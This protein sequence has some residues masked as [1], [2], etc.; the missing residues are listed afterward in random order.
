MQQTGEASRIDPKDTESMADVITSIALCPDANKVFVACGRKIFLFNSH[1]DAMG[2]LSES[3]EAKGSAYLPSG[4]TPDRP[5]PPISFF[6]GRYL[7]IVCC[8]K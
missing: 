1:P 4:L 6:L 8:V 7:M 5:S 2:S 3:D